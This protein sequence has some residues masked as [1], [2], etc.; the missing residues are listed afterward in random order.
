[1]SFAW[2]SRPGQG[3][4][5]CD[6]LAPCHPETGGSSSLI[7]GGEFCFILI[8]Q[9]EKLVGGDSAREGYKRKKTHTEERKAH[10]NGD[11]KFLFILSKVLRVF[12]FVCVCGQG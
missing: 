3:D 10:M 7:F 11:E 6:L 1:M 9:R 12:L 4:A 2:T 5:I 8:C